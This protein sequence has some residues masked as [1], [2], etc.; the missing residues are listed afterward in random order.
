[1]KSW[2]LGVLSNKAQAPQLQYQASDQIKGL[3]LPDYCC[4]YNGK[5]KHCKMLPVF[6]CEYI[7]INV[8]MF[9]LIFFI[10]LVYN[11]VYH[12][13]SAI[14]YVDNCKNNIC[15]LISVAVCNCHSNLYHSTFVY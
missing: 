12:A 11:V 4:Y 2:F 13:T 6:I 9:Q 3:F 1:L 14:G 5:D 15:Y 10:I 8:P 7:T